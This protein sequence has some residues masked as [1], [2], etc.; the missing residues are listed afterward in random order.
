MATNRNRLE[1]RWT[2]DSREKATLNWL[3]IEVTKVF[4]WL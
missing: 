4:F 1:A 2:P 3:Q